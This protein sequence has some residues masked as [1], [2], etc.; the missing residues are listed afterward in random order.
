MLLVGAVTV[1]VGAIS[2]FAFVRT[3]DLAHHTASAPVPVP[4]E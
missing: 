4:G 2:A 3:R 1:A